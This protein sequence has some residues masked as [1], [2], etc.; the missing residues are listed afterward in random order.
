MHF[1]TGNGG[2]LPLFSTFRQALA[3][4]AELLQSCRL[5]TG[6][7]AVGMDEK[8]RRLFSC[9][10][11][12]RLLLIES[13]SDVVEMRIDWYEFDTSADVN[14]T[15]HRDTQIATINGV[16]S[17]HPNTFHRCTYKPVRRVVAR[18]W[19]ARFFHVVKDCHRFLRL[20]FVLSSIIPIKT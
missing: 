3:S 4:L 15:L 5:S 9:G 18:Y 20:V 7:T 1:H 11:I 2:A 12:D 17:C 16:L 14:D 8:E 6:N 13:D 19:R 10:R